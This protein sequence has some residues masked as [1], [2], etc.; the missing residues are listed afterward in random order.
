VCGG[1]LNVGLWEEADQPRRILETVRARKCRAVGS[2]QIDIEIMMWKYGR[3]RVHTFTVVVN[4]RKEAM[5]K[6]AGAQ[7]QEKGTA[8]DAEKAKRKRDNRVSSS[9]HR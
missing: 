9:S 8:E 2:Q 4:K 3:K 7:A 1:V 5:W 6:V